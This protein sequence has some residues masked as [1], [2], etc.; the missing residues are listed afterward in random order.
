MNATITITDLEF[1]VLW[2][3]YTGELMPEPLSFMSRTEYHND[4][5][6]EKVQVWERIRTDSFLGKVI[7]TLHVPDVYVIAHG[8]DDADMANPKKRIR[9]R[10]ARAGAR[11][12]VVTQLPGETLSH[13]GGFTITDCGARGI[14]AA[15]VATLPDV[16]AGQ[17]GSV[18]IVVEATRAGDSYWQSRSMVADA[19]DS[20]QEHSME[21]L[22]LP[23]TTT[24]A[25][26]IHQG[27]SKFGRRGILEQAM[28]WRD[29][30]DDGRY[31]IPL[32]ENPVAI[33]I[34]TRRLIGLIEDG[35][36][37]MVE[38][39]ETHWET[40]DSESMQYRRRSF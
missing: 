1:K 30:L 38:R 35:I 18:P 28:L 31:V 9:V 21:F 29:M 2:E 15:V 39:L 22:G 8:W 27:K 40:G 19:V 16:K 32:G 26:T 17:R 11:G 37:V 10:A 6:R 20:A 7:E 3:R 14:P 12:Y 25:I 23:A 4:Y 5:E 13:S 36:E 33:P 34:G 24:G